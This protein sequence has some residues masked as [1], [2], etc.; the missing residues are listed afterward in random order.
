MKLSNVFLLVIFLL[1]VSHVASAQQK[2]LKVVIIRHGEK[3]ATGDNLNCQ[4]LNRALALPKV[5]Y[6]KFGIPAYILVPALGQGKSTS[7]SR[8][9]QTITPFAGKYNISINTDFD[10]TDYKDIK[11]YLKGKS[12]TALLVWDH[13]SIEGLAKSFG[14]KDEKLKWKDSDYDSIWIIDMKKGQKV[15]TRSAEGIRPG[16]ACSF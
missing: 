5:L 3:G 13:Q 16:T 2:D 4:G 7:H 11:D 1:G 6:A 14:I 9:F 12:G 15:L 10:S 8:M